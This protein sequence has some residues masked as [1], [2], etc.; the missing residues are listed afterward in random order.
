MDF[1][2]LKQ[3]QG[4]GPATE[5]IVVFGGWAIGPQV[6]A[7]LAGPQDIL[8]ASDYTALE[9]ELPDLS[10]YDSVALVAWSFGVAAYAH[11]QQSR[12][13]PFARK[14]A[15]NGSL[16]P[17]SR[18]TG[19]PPA[20]FRRTVETL[21][22]ASF[23]QFLTRVFGAPQP[24]QPLDV[25]ARRAELL[26]VEARGDAPH[27]AF[28]RVWISSADKIFPPANL[29]RAWEGQPVRSIDAPHAPFDWFSSW[30]ALLQ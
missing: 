5:A 8:F 26:A 3:A 15:V 10:A 29:A 21:D 6:F 22:A 16:S 25:T 20:I 12:P 7:H 11:W 24:D 23:Q 28:D 18:N 13:D 30:E 27:V 17:V 4:H 1:R 19:I 14:V 2:W 9:A